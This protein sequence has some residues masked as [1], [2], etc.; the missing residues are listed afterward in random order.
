ME[1]VSLQD[2]WIEIEDKI[3]AYLLDGVREI[4]ILIPTQRAARV[5]TPDVEAPRVIK[6]HERLESADLLPGFS[7][8]LAS[9]FADLDNA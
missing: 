1:V 2:R 8:P 4:W 9:I 5:Y 6:A 3:E 7:L